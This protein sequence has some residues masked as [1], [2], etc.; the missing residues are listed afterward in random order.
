M[1]NRWGNNGKSE[2]FYFWAG[3]KK[4]LQ[5]VTAAM[6][7]KDACS[8][9]KSYDRPRQ[10]IKKQRHY[11]ANKGPFSQSYG[12]SSS[13]V[14][15]WELDYKENWAPKN[16]CFW[17]VVI[18][19]TLAS[20]LDCKEIKPVNPKENQPWIFIGR[21]DAEAETPILWPPDA[22]NWLTGVEK[23][24]RQEEKGT[25][26]GWDG[27][28]TSLTWLTGVWASSGSWWWTGKPGVLQYTGL[29]RVGH[30]SSFSDWTE[31]EAELS[32][33]SKA[34]LFFLDLSSLILASPPS[35]IS[36]SLNLLFGTQA[37][38]WKLKP[39]SYKQ[40]MEYVERLPFPGAPQSDAAF[41]YFYHHSGQDYWGIIRKTGFFPIAPLFSFWV[42]IRIIFNDSFIAMWIISFLFSLFF[43]CVGSSLF[44][45]GSLLWQVGFSSC[46][47]RAPECSGFSRS[48]AWAQLPG[49]CRILVPHPGMEPTAPALEGKFLN[50]GPPRGPPYSFF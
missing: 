7:L 13:H 41:Q 3:A 21:T 44:T 4:S 38:W 11:F 32:P 48:G 8:W 27:W 47:V 36:K 10:H 26:R 50:I 33:C 18:E 23:D 35:L 45:W 1:T 49:A 46:G 42:L 31:L 37:K 16:W 29:Q 25:N 43:G 39:V 19:K 2:R 6:K 30:F 14:W 12:F 40:E 15:V 34:A 9:K 20:P 5:M 28:M 17:T 24:W 22:K